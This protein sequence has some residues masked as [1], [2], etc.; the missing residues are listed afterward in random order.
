MASLEELR[1]F[2]Q[3]VIRTD[4]HEFLKT[5]LSNLPKKLAAPDTWKAST[6]PTVDTTFPEMH[7]L[8]KSAQYFLCECPIKATIIKKLEPFSMRL[9]SIKNLILLCHFFH[10][11]NDWETFFREEI[12]LDI[13]FHK[14]KEMCMILFLTAKMH[15]YKYFTEEEFMK[16]VKFITYFLHSKS[17]IWL[18]QDEIQ[19]AFKLH[20]KIDF[21]APV[22]RSAV[23]DIFESTNKKLKKCS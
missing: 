14:I 5:F 11:Q 2:Q 19:H 17:D 22:K 7:Q 20:D 16:I 21:N 15:R 23:S 12:M 6:S 3:F 9:A 1:E 8:I 4:M 13:R 10:G 18:M